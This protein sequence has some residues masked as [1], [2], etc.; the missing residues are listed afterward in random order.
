M[1]N[2]SLATN[3]DWY[4]KD[5]SHKLFELICLISVILYTL[6]CFIQDFRHRGNLK[7]HIESFHVDDKFQ[8]KKKCPVCK[9][10]CIF[11]SFLISNLI[12][13]RIYYLFS[14]DKKSQ[15]TFS[16]QNAYRIPVK[17]ESSA[18]NVEKYIISSFS[19]INI[20]Y[21][22]SFFSFFQILATKHS[23]K[24]HIQV[25]HATESNIFKCETCGNVLG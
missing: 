16:Y 21:Y 14:D 1:P 3:V 18:K 6:L 25:M 4:L 20:T 13:I 17:V 24:E 10:V 11:Q 23:L 22:G 7:N 19:T 5:N 12:F 8:E 9:E 2:L 15:H